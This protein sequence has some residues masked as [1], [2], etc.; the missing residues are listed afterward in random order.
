M[1]NLIMLTQWNCKFDTSFVKLLKLEE[2]AGVQKENVWGV[3]G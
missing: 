2:E 1:D 3:G